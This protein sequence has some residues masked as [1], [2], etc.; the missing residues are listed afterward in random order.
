MLPGITQNETRTGVS[1]PQEFLG[2]YVQGEDY[3]P[4]KTIIDDVI[5]DAFA[6]QLALYRHYLV[7]H[8]IC[9]MHCDQGRGVVNL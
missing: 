2:F 5:Y 7:L 6:L 8:H 3:P 1:G 9:K 4:H